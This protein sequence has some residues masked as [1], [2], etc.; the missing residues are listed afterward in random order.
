MPRAWKRS[1]RP[2]GLR[3]SRHQVKTRFQAVRLSDSAETAKVFV[4]RDPA[5]CFVVPATDVRC[6]QSLIDLGKGWVLVVGNKSWN[7]SITYHVTRY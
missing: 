2:H 1:R 4:F 3:R 7:F 6:L 5:F